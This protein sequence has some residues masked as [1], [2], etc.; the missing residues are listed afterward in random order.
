[1]VVKVTKPQKHFVDLSL[2]FSPHPM[3][4]DIT[5]LR[6][7]RAINASLKNCIMIMLEEK[8]FNPDF[9]SRIL[10]LMF[11]VID[12][13]SASLLR[14]EIERSIE[15]NEPRVNLQNVEVQPFP[16]L[17]EYRIEVEYLIVGYDEVITFTHILTPTR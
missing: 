3:T 12:P 1:M 8:P 17:N 7:H 2:A 16:E 5:V 4:G 10:D 15:Y 13:A 11:E 9:G 6:G 14:Q